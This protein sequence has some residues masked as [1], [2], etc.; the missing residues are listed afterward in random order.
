[1]VVGK[2]A[3][4]CQAHLRGP[5]IVF[6]LKK[7]RGDP[8]PGDPLNECEMSGC[9]HFVPETT[10]DSHQR[11]VPVK[12]DKAQSEQLPVYGACSLRY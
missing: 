11:E 2:A 8:Y 7:L 6:C 5:R 4:A 12:L 3:R 9:G 1:M 10:K